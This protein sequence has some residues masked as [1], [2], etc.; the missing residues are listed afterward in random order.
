MKKIIIG[1]FF[2]ILILVIVGLYVSYVYMNQSFIW[3]AGI[4]LLL[5]T[6]FNWFLYNKYLSKKHNKGAR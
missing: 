1:V 6:L 4:L 3:V 5:G 2:G